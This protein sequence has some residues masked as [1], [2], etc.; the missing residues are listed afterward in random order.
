MRTAWAWGP[1]FSILGE[2]WLVTP[3]LYSL[4]ACV[5]P[6]CVCLLAVCSGSA[7]ALCVH[8]AHDGVWRVSE[9]YGSDPDPCRGSGSQA[10]GGGT[11]P[12][13]PAPLP[14]CGT[15]GAVGAPPP[16]VPG[17]CSP[18]QHLQQQQQLPLGPWLAGRAA[19]V[20]GGGRVCRGTLPGRPAWS[21]PHIWA[22]LGHFMG[23]CRL[24]GRP[25]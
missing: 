13:G 17:P 24:P 21:H 7:A 4:C 19:A 8:S 6:L 23:C 18:G 10:A 20:W 9:Q 14:V 1:C 12:S 3:R 15:V 25:R 11:D 16:V 5:P 22:E 2:A